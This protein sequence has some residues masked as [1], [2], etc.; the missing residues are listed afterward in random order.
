MMAV[1]DLAA[2]WPRGVGYD[3]DP[4][5]PDARFWDPRV[6]AIPAGALVLFD[7][8]FTDFARWA[9]LT[10]RRVSW[11]SRAKKNLKYEVVHVL[12][13]TATVRDRVVWIGAGATRQQGRLIE[14]QA[15]GTVYR[16]LTNALEPARLPTAQAVALCTPSA[17]GSKS[18]S[19]T[20][21]IR[22]IHCR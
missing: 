11:L 5:G 22:V 13:T 8:G 6:A 3:A 1:L 19:H 21:S 16:Y 14:V 15:H 18:T 12:V 4:H 2:R 20:T 7:L 17:G 10:A 9:T